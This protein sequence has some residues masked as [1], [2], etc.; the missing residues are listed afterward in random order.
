MGLGPLTGRLLDTVCR[1][2]LKVGLSIKI[3][4]TVKEE[5]EEEEEESLTNDLERCKRLA[6]SLKHCLGITLSESPALI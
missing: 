4:S 3:C 2:R 6:D 5:E 1:R